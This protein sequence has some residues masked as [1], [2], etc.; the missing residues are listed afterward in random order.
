MRISISITFAML[1]LAGL[2]LLPG[3]ARAHSH[4]HGHSVTTTK[5]GMADPRDPKVAALGKH[6]YEEHCAVC[7]GKNGEGQPNWRQRKP[8]GTLPAPP[9]DGSGHTWHHSD[10]QNFKYT[11]FGG[12]ALALR[13]F[14]SGM[15]G[16]KDVL[17][18]RE[19]RAALAHIKTFWP[20]HIRER[21]GRRH[22]RHR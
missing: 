12:A 5:F 11:K 20:R 18:D 21:H 19:I 7:H 6:V 15:P 17:S 13:G 16:F 3:E 2:T 10:E 8:D 4:Y 22:H 9:H 14:K 1:V